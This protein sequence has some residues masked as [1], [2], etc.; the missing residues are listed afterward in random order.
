MPTRP[1]AKPALRKDL[2]LGGGAGALLC[3]LIVGAALSV[4]PLFG[5]TFSSQN[6]GGTSPEAIAKLPAIPDV[7]TPAAEAPRPRARVPRVLDTQDQPVT[8]GRRR[9]AVPASRPTRA[10]SRAPSIVDRRP[11]AS[12]TPAV[13][14]PPAPPDDAGTV[15]APEAPAAPPAPVVVTPAA[16]IPV[17]PVPAMTKAVRL[18]VASLAVTAAADGSPEL[19]LGLSL[20][21]GTPNTPVPDQVTVRLRP[22]LPDRATVA[23]ADAPLALQAHVDV[24]AATNGAGVS[25]TG[26]TPGMA[27][28]VRMTLAPTDAATPVTAPTVADAGDGDGQSNVIALVVPLAAFAAPAA[29]PASPSGETSGPPYGDDGTPAPPADSPAPPADSPAPPPAPAE[30]TEVILNLAPATDAN[31]KPQ[32][33][34]ATVPAP[35]APAGAPQTAPADVPVTVVLDTTPAPAPAPPADTTTPPAA[36]T[37]APPADTTTTPPADAT[38]TAPATAPD[39]AAT[40]AAPGTPPYGAAAADAPP[41]VPSTNAAT[42]AGDATTASA[43]PA[44]GS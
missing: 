34:T 42:A 33:D 14:R 31:P 12:S 8:G 15:P 2:L 37:T 23:S 32:A 6:T 44:A 9:A 29:P 3:A 1:P 26:D 19:A 30:P 28:R 43:P 36:T 38:A 25:G 40:T 4:G 5:T 11:Q 24:V 13:T 17:T 21:R 7:P 41:A 39:A 35:D 16:A 27:M 18:R 20:D 22:Q 10:A